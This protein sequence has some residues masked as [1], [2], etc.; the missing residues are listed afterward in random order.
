MIDGLKSALNRIMSVIPQEVL[1]AAF[2]PWDSDMTLDAAILKK[3]LLSRVRDDI[4]VRGGKI[5]KIMLNL[6][7]CEYTSSPSP[8]A[9]GISGSYSTYR[10][11]PEAR[12]NRD[13]SCVLSVRFPYTISTSTSGSFY[14]SAALKGNNLQ[15]LA[16]AALQSQT[17]NDLL[18]SPTGIIR[19]GNVL[20]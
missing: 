20:D 15:G 14:N 12:E 1:M 2:T 3:V 16:C 19:P 6:D 18:A 7:W 11:P 5:L 4:S 8:Y 13:I 10:I 9:L 17:G